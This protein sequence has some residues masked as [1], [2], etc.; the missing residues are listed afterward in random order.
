M[1]RLKDPWVCDKCGRAK[2][3]GNGWLIGIII[4]SDGAIAR[5]INGLDPCV[6]YGGYA[7]VSWDERLAYAHQD[8]VHHLC[9]EA[10]A[11]AKQ[12]EHLRP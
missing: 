9:S 8:S 6:T 11:L 5:P 7:I 2:G 4:N 1:A 3:E 12:G 10:C